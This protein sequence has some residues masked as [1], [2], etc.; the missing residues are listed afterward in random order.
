MYHSYLN[1]KMNENIQK[2]IAGDML[3]KVTPQLNKY[4]TSFTLTELH[5]CYCEIIENK[6]FFEKGLSF[7]N[8]Y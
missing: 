2:S 6:E 7:L 8:I 4:K 3:Q 1:D 5:T